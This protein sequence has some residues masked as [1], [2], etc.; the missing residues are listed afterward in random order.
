[1][2]KPAPK[3]PR[4]AVRT[5]LHRELLNGPRDT[6]QLVDTLGAARSTVALYIRQLGAIRIGD[7]KRT[8]NG[9]RTAVWILPESRQ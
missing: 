9:R 1:M 6:D 8:G 2:S 4:S 5:L 7:V 3:T